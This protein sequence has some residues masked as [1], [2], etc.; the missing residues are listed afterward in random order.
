[1]FIVRG[2]IAITSLRSMPS[3]IRNYTRV[4]VV[5]LAYH[6]AAL[7]ER[8]SPLE[9]PLFEFGKPDSLLPADGIIPQ[10]FEARF[11]ALQKRIRETYDDQLLKRVQAIL[12]ACRAWG[13]RLIVFPEYSIPWEIL[14]GVAD[15]AG[16]MVVVAGT[17]AV[18]RTARKSEIY[19]RLG[20]NQPPARGASVCPVLHQGRLLALQ[21]KLNPAKPET[22]SLQ[23]GQTWQPVAL[24]DGIPGPLGVMI[25][26]D[27]LHREGPQHRDLVAGGLEQ[28]RFLAVPSLTPHYTINEFS[29]KAWEEARRYRRPVLYADIAS[30]GGTSIYVDERDVTDLRRFPDRAGYLEKGDEGV[31]VAD[32]DLGF[33]RIGESTPYDYQ[34]P[35]LPVAEASLVY[36]SHSIGDEYATFLEELS[37]LLAGD[38]EK[39]L[40]AAM[41]RVETARQ[42]LLNAG[43]GEGASARQRRL[44]R[45]LGEIDNITRAEEL[46]RFTREVILPGDQLPLADLRAALAKGAADVV[47]AWLRERRGG[48]LEMVETRLR[49]AGQRIA[50]PAP[51]LWTT[52]GVR[53]LGT[54]ADALQ[55][56]PEIA[57]PEVHREPE[58][59]VRVVLPKGLNPATLGDRKCNGF[60]F[61]FLS[62]PAELLWR[63]GEYHLQAPEHKQ[64][65]HSG[66]S[67]AGMT[68]A[69]DLYLLARAE[70]IQTVAAVGVRQEDDPDVALFV[71]FQQADHWVI[72][73]DGKHELLQRHRQAIVEALAG[74]CLGQVEIEIIPEATLEDRLNPLLRRFEGAH[75]VIRQFH[76]ERLRD[77]AGHFVEPDVLVGG[78]DK[79]QPAL[80]A[81]DAWLA[82]D[83][84]TALVLGEFG[85]GKSTTLARWALRVCEQKRGPLPILCNLAGAGPSADAELLL[86]KASG[87]EDTP[88]NRAALNLLIRGRRLLPCFDGFDE[89]ATRLTPSE[90]AGRLSELLRVAR[91]GGRVVISS[92]DHYFPSEENLR[93]TAEQALAQA[94]GQSAG[95]RRFTLQLFNEKQVQELVEQIRGTGPSTEAALARI[96]SLYPLKELV[97]RPLLLGMVLTTLDTIEPGARVSRADLYEKYLGRWLEQTHH[98]G[99]QEVFTDAQKAT[100]AEALA[101]QLWRSGEP[102]CSPREL[103]QSV[104]AVLAKDLPEDMS[105]AAAFLETY[106]GSFF[107]REGDDRYRFA[108]KSFLEFFL[109]RGLVRTIPERPADVL[110]TKP[111]TPEIAA[112]VGE[113]LRREGDPKRSKTLQALHAWLVEG[114]RASAS[115]DRMI[116]ATAP[117]A[118]NA[119]RL[120]L[121][122]SRWAGDRAG[123]FPENAD[124]RKVHLVGEDLREVSLIVADLSD[125][126]LS[127]ANLSDADLRDAQLMR[128]RLV[129]TRLDRALLPRIHA[130]GADFTLAEGDRCHLE[131]ADLS[132]AAL[133]QSCWTTPFRDGIKAG[134]ADVTAWTMTGNQSLAEPARS[135]APLPPGIA[136]T[137]AAGHAGPVEAVAWSPLGDR[138]ASAGTDGTVRLWDAASG[139]ELT[140]LTGHERGVWAVAWSP[141][142]GRLASAGSDATVR[143]WETSSG[144]ELTRLP[145]HVSGVHAV[146]WSPDGGRLASAG[147]DGTVRLWEGASGKELTCLAGHEGGVRAL[148]WSSHDG[149]LASAGGDGMVRLW[150]V[151]SGQELTCLAGHEGGVLAVAWSRDGRLLA[152]AGGDGT[153]RLWDVASGQELT[154]PAG[155]AG[156]A[157]AVAWSPDGRRLASAGDDGT[158][159]LWEAASGKELACLTGHV[160]AVRALAWSP[161]GGRLASAGSDATM[162]LW[163]AASGKE[164]A[165]LTG[166]ADA[167]RTLT[168][169]PNGGQLALA[170]SDGTVRLWEAASGREL[171]RLGGHVGGVLALAWS[172]DGGQ[173]AS[174]GGDGMV[175]L[176]GAA[177]GQE[178]TRLAGQEGGVWAVAWSPDGRRLASAGDNGTLRL[179][180]AVTGQ[181]LRHLAGH[182]GVVL[183]VAWSP[184]DGRLASAGEDGTV[185]LWEAASGREL[186]HL[187]GHERW[188]LAVAWSRDGRLLASAGDDGTVRVWDAASGQE[189]ACL[190]G[191][192]RWMP[193][194]A[195]SP[196]DG[197]LASA[198][199]DGT[200]R[201]WEAAGGEELPRLAGHVGGVLALA[202]SPNGGRLASAGKD[203][204][205][206]IWSVG[207]GRLLCT[208]ETAG[209]S[210]LVRTAGGFCL[211]DGNTE[212]YRFAVAR[213]DRPGTVLYLPLGGFREVLNRPDKVKAA[214]AGDLS[215]DD[216]KTEFEKRGWTGGVP[217]DGEVWKV[218]S[219]VPQHAPYTATVEEATVSGIGELLSRID[220]A[221]EHKLNGF[222]P[223]PAL[224]EFDSLPGREPVIRELLGLIDARS[225]AI[226]L[227]P[228]RSGK[229]SIFHAL[230]RRLASGRPVR[231]ITLEGAGVRTAD[232]LARC[233][234]PELRDTPKPAEALRQRLRTEA[235]PVILLD[236]LAHLCEAD[237]P[238]LTWLRVVG[239]K[240]EASLVLAG[241]HWDWVSVV[242][243]A[244][245]EPSRRGGPARGR[246]GTRPRPARGRGS[247]FGND[248]TLVKLGPMPPEDAIEFL[249]TTAAAKDVPL[250]ATRTAAW[251]VELCGPWPFYLQVMGNAVVQAVHSGK[252]SALVKREG[253][254]EL[255]DE[256]LLLD[257]DSVFRARWHELPEVARAVIATVREGQLPAYRTLSRAERKAVRDT[258]LCTSTGRWLDDR[259][260]FDWIQQNADDLKGE[261]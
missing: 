207:P 44:R 81:L 134:G 17:H 116:V 206:R 224:T 201:L 48:G 15:A 88:E 84:Q 248:A 214:L 126:E 249:V 211:F 22:N 216:L 79:R 41:E 52:A 163:E 177:S 13:V 104:R 187:T 117:A 158:V 255:Y 14:G 70:G 54:I 178:L 99:Q 113:L 66:W 150:D 236:E 100:L 11:K 235:N 128:A 238:T 182:A 244:A 97:A 10:Q 94:L 18:D 122:L 204:T 109:A 46:H 39:S 191:H 108:H 232:D 133:R 196:D 181:E 194:V 72:W 242:E 157:L 63:L 35:V 19:E 130:A 197:R 96:A 129:G 78:G 80:D 21:P 62:K 27:F 252:R 165:C 51:S 20:I 226:L 208:L 240:K 73:T 92:R 141:N 114:R 241:S 250:E 152:S 9:D 47:F 179:W 95:L 183:A 192:E 174:A 43:A 145:G 215:G 76:D 45:L 68:I 30:G 123:W 31:I 136:A 83:E 146:A 137:I 38:E 143:L 16:D 107:V 203:R 87:C 243:H 91:G 173:L 7:L 32:V 233:L 120:F 34:P 239:Q 25:C 175:R 234:E 186:T 166:H 193:A 138:L 237:V 36:R 124:L 245:K 115:S 230:T 59:P 251:I 147:S 86:L 12:H 112:F 212:H 132:G 58:S 205:V 154:R 77:V 26:L 125:A 229:T 82:S 90:L 61:H 259:P 184:D 200:V 74:D 169:S 217:W 189:L 24:P 102:S 131:E 258:G 246:R 151:A 195:W 172:P 69:E 180:E 156:V 228:R 199:E 105:L 42:L 135:V 170:E 221:P 148:A 209:P 127:G 213:P 155:H 4:A 57:K 218:P 164:L 185:R 160:N 5:Q 188:V 65:M 40:D 28:C 261:S 23:P 8:R 29:A 50:T 89:M 60:V 210:T 121:G 118:A 231:H 85:S 119:V 103:E 64:T 53:V 93:T 1:V 254:L 176:W 253:V 223:G 110:T 161:D 190:T 67:H 227:G 49:E 167:V 139:Q 33:V 6:P 171:R 256:H 101:E 3:V 202:W 168:W 159:R 2:T 149:Q 247:S 219:V 56:P 142:D 71:V 111:I 198:G 225:P 106:G 162:R 257:R 98:Q 153:V 222:R 140:R 220:E 144:Q 55:E 260:F 37:S 75:A